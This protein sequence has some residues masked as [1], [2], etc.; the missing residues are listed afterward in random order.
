MPLRSIQFVQTGKKYAEGQ[1]LDQDMR[2]NSTTGDILVA[3]PLRSTQGLS[4]FNAT[5]DVNSTAT[6]YQIAI[7]TLTYIKKQLTTQK[8]FEQDVPEFVPLVV[9]D[10][11]FSNDILTN[12]VFSNSD[13]FETGNI[14]SGESGSRL[15]QADSSVASKTIKVIKW[16]KSIGYTLF[17]IEQALQANNWDIIASKHHSRQKNFQL[18][19]QKIAFLGSSS[20]TGVA[21]LLNNSAVNINTSRITAPISGLSAANLATFVQNIVNDYYANTNSTALPNRFVMPM[22]DF[23]GMGA[24]TPGTVGTY[25]VPVIKY[26]EEVFQRVCGAGFKILA[27]PYADTTNA[28]NAASVNKHVYA[29]YRH[30]PESIRMDIPVDYTTTQPNSLNNFS[31]NDVAYAQYTGVGFY[32]NLETLLF[33]Y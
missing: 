7:D 27:T 32:R 28:F 23:L 12:L 2:V 1:K 6:G 22:S 16:A 29:L 21:G 15:A 14:N 3:K 31:F 30:D 25:P 33:Q 24:L 17:D 19:I 18:G 26:L 10:G 11:A 20:D 5:G 9:G 8:F 13:D 4:L